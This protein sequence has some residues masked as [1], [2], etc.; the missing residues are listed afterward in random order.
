M[1][2][3][4]QPTVCYPKRPQHEHY[5]RLVKQ[6]EVL[7]VPFAPHEELLQQPLSQAYDV[8][9]DAAFGFSFKGAPRPPFDELLAALAP[10]AQ[11]PPVVAVDVPSGW[12]VDEGDPTGEGLRPQVLVSL[13]APK[14]CAG[15]FTGEHHF[16][17]GRFVPPV[18]KRKYGLVVPDY[19]GA[20]QIVRLGP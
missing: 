19:P 20:A 1:H 9:V 18:I 11:P 2:F 15:H 17:G 4:Y 5:A 6:L 7:G 12:T 8:A 3:G 16:L 13:T 10:A 14:P